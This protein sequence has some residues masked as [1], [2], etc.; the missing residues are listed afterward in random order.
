MVNKQED[1]DSDTKRPLWIQATSMVNASLRA[2]ARPPYLDRICLDCGLCGLQSPSTGNVLSHEAWH[3]IDTSTTCVSKSMQG[4]PLASDK[5]MQ[6]YRA[7][8]SKLLN[9]S[10]V[11]QQ[12]LLTFIG[13]IARNSEVKC[14]AR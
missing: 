11:L 7:L 1:H 10:R 13:A 2:E 3:W 8:F 9:G 6:A 5:L 12:Q 4:E 14:P